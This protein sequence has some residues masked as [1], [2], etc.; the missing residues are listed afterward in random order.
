M[1]IY[2]S[3]GWLARAL[4][5]TIRL[6]G[7]RPESYLAK[8]LCAGSITTSRTRLASGSPSYA[9]LFSRLTFFGGFFFATGLAL[10]GDT[11]FFAAAFSS[12]AGFAG[13]AGFGAASGFAAAGFPLASGFA[14][15][16]EVAAG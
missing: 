13:G 10:G 16:T 11:G 1:R 8:F 6:E 3:L 2:A 7:T 4:A 14:V 5:L 15:T 12:L 9:Y